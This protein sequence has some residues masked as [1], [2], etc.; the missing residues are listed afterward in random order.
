MSRN[1]GLD[2]RMSPLMFQPWEL[3]GKHIFCPHNFKVRISRDPGKTPGDK[4]RLPLKTDVLWPCG[5]F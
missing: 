1:P 4:I 5:H 2:I 3:I